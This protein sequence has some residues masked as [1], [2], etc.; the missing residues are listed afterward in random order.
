[1]HNILTATLGAYAASDLRLKN[2]GW[3]RNFDPS[4][5]VKLFCCCQGQN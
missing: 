1:V 4:N 2:D 3:S 5:N